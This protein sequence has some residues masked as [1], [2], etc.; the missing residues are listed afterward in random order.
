[1][2]RFPVVLDS[3][4]LVSSRAVGGVASPSYLHIGP[5]LTSEA[6]QRIDPI[7]CFCLLTLSAP[8]HVIDQLE[9][10]AETDGGPNFPAS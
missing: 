10:V 1:M 7:R 3:I 6:S 5:S 9:V 8:T 2:F 4:V